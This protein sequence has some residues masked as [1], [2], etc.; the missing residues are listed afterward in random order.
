MSQRINVVGNGVVDCVQA[1]VVNNFHNGSN[2]FLVELGGGHASQRPVTKEQR[3]V[4]ASGDLGCL[5]NG[6][7]SNADRDGD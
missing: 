6:E 7:W 1:A 5:S 3:A 4:I 2:S